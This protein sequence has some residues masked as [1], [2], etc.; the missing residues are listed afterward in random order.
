MKKHIVL[1]GVIS[2]SII[3][4]SII[5]SLVTSNAD[6]SMAALEWLGYLVMLV[7]L[8]VIFVAIK[9]YRDQELGGV[10]KFGT[11]LLMGLGISLVASLIYVLAWE[12]HL[13]ITDYAF[14][15]TYIA[16]VISAKEAAGVTGAE[17][18]QIVVEMDQLKTRYSNPLFRLFITFSEIFPVGLLVSLIS[19]AVL[20]NAKVLPANVA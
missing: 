20:R 15:D 6:T 4:S 2:G 8:S 14:I 7:A 1:Y 3:I 12:A 18:E 5:L 11:A 10:I 9:R 19:A 16:G 13:A 17:L